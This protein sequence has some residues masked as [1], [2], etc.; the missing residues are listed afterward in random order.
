M[1]RRKNSDSLG[2]ATGRC[3]MPGT[4]SLD[5]TMRGLRQHKSQ[6]NETCRNDAKIMN[7]Q[8]L[9]HRAADHAGTREAY[10]SGRV[11][12]RE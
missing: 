6:C 11:V 3:A 10:V 1:A 4:G 12:Q 7:T 9:E 5:A 2:F 8:R